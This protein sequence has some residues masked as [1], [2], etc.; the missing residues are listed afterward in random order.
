MPEFQIY[1]SLC[2]VGKLAVVGKAHQG[3]QRGGS[4]KPD[5]FWRKFSYWY[6][7]RRVAIDFC[8]LFAGEVAA[9]SRPIGY[10]PGKKGR[11]VISPKNKRGNQ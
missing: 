4:G 1:R 5:L 2:V 6:E 7:Q 8:Y 9:G 11:M 10:P 3:P